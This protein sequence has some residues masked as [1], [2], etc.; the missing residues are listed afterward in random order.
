MNAAALYYIVQGDVER[1]KRFNFR[2]L[3]FAFSILVIRI[4]II[5]QLVAGWESD[6]TPAIRIS[7]PVSVLVRPRLIKRPGSPEMR[8]PGSLSETTG[9]W[10]E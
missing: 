7:F 4:V 8:S 10:T 2:A 3:M 5:I 1:H 9:L 6:F